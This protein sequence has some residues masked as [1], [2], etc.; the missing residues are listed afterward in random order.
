MSAAGR[1]PRGGEGRDFYETPPQCTRLIIEALGDSVNRDAWWL[2]PACGNGAIESVLNEYGI[3]KVIATDIQ[4]GPAYAGMFDYVH[5]LDYLRFVRHPVDK[6]YEVAITNPPYKL[7][8]EF[9]QRMVLD[10]RVA[11]AL[12]PLSFLGSK[13]RQAW[14]SEHPPNLYVLS[15]RPS[16]CSKA[17]CDGTIYESTAEYVVTSSQCRWTKLVEHGTVISRCPACSTLGSVTVRPTTDAAEYAWFVWG[18]P[19]QPI[20]FLRSK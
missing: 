3:T 6:C 17:T 19:P 1:S 11:V 12:L 20:Q 5:E 13:K 2:E 9:V 16:F 10:A 8:F 7:A 14:L 18:L 4:P 15:E